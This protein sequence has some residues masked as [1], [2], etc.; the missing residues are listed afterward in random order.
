MTYSQAYKKCVRVDGGRDTV[1]ARSS[2]LASKYRVRIDFL[3]RTVSQVVA[4]AIKDTLGVSGV[5]LARYHMEVLET[6]VGELAETDELVQKVRKQRRVSGTGEDAEEWEILSIEMPGKTESAKA[7][8]D[9]IGANAPVKTESKVSQTVDL[10]LEDMMASA[11]GMHGFGVLLR[12]FPEAV[13]AMMDGLEGRD[14]TEPE[15]ATA[16]PPA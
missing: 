2:E 9:L 16:L 1:Y 14:Y 5:S 3:R 7:L 15:A 8:A 11:P 6:P 12:N 4:Q 13:R 10:S